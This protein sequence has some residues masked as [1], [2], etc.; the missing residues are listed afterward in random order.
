MVIQLPK[1]IE[2]RLNEL[3][4][5]K[6][7]PADQLAADAIEAML[8]KNESARRWPPPKVVGIVDEGDSHADDRDVTRSS[9]SS[10]PWAKMIGMLA[11][12]GVPATEFDE[13]LEAERASDER[14]ARKTSHKG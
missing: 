12:G 10:R 1:D 5:R 13:W 14:F 6:G 3:A 2:E 7:T 9:N 4:E 11:D 8:E